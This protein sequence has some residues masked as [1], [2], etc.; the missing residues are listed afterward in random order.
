[1]KKVHN[2]LVLTPGS[3]KFSNVLMRLGVFT[4]CNYSFDYS[5]G[6]SITRFT[7]ETE[8]LITHYAELSCRGVDPHF[9]I[10][11]ACYQG[12]FIAGG[13]WG[14]DQL[15]YIF[16]RIRPHD[17]RPTI[18]VTSDLSHDDLEGWGLED[19][20]PT[21]QELFNHGPTCMDHPII[22]TA[23]ISCLLFYIINLL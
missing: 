5:F 7:I 13:E 10:A 16:S 8:Y 22:V 11:G 21:S 23:A 15:N 19:K 9:R 1:M 6:D 18:K 20:P 3:E 12:L 14:R 17:Y 2:C 4:G